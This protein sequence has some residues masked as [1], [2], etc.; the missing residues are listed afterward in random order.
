MSRYVTNLSR[1]WR[2]LPAGVRSAGLNLASRSAGLLAVRQDNDD[3]RARWLELR[4]KITAYR[5]FEG[6]VDHLASSRLDSYS[7]LFAAEGYGYRYVLWALRAEMPAMLSPIAIHAGVGLQLAEQTLININDG[8]GEEDLLTDFLLACEQNARNGYSGIMQETLGLVAW[9]LYPHWIELLNKRLRVMSVLSRE[10]F[11]HGVGRGIYFV[12]GNISPSCAAPW[13]GIHM[14][15]SEPPDET[16]KLNALAGF[17]FALTLVNLRQ[18]E[19][20]ESFF[21][22]HEA[23]AVNCGDGIH[24]ALAVSELSRKAEPIGIA[25]EYCR[26]PE[27]LFSAL[28]GGPHTREELALAIAVAQ[29]ELVLEVNKDEQ[30]DD[31][32]LERCEPVSCTSRFGTY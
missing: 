10:R 7:R 12:P 27:R 24:A 16:A 20:F 25:R 32:G 23:E 31:A 14:C 2:R 28:K 26:A 18:P 13:K 8:K 29:S 6:C 1:L 22:H 5:L 15:I 21:K 11:W 17:C 9:T 19:V 30:H 4:N 3:S